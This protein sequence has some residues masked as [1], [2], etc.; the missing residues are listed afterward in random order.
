MHCHIILLFSEFCKATHNYRK[1]RSMK[2][3]T[4]KGFILQ[5][6]RFFNLNIPILK[7][8][9]VF[10]LCD[11]DETCTKAFEA[12]GRRHAMS[13]YSCTAPNFLYS[14]PPLPF[15]MRIN[16]PMDSYH[17]TGNIQLCICHL[18]LWAGFG[19]YFHKVVV[20]GEVNILLGIKSIRCCEWGAAGTR[21]LLRAKPT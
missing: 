8:D 13:Q 10:C 9:R 16:F 6:T 21:A 1:I 2:F 20:Q 17:L 7:K 3:S 11:P 18:R 15:F 12:H 5:S 19:C 4:C 14:A